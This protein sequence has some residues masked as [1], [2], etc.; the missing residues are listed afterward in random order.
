LKFGITGTFDCSYL[1]G[2]KERLLVFA[3]SQE[4][5]LRSQYELMLAHGF[6]R[7]GE[8]IYRPNCPACEA[9]QSIRIPVSSFKP[10]KSQKRV[11][12]KN[13]SLK[14]QV[15]RVHSSEYYELY[16]LYINQ[17]HADGGMYPASPEQYQQFLFSTWME[18]MFIE[19]REENELV[20][21]AVVDEMNSC[22]SALY[23][24]FD[25]EYAHRSLGTFA[26]LEQ[27]HRAGQMHKE[28][29]YLGYQI[30][31]CRKMN[32]KSNFFPHERHLGEGWMVVSR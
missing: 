12:A 8:Q 19:F 24:F 15:S 17:R 27:I 31:E 26:I 6:R 10:S 11:L 13:K 25:P 28:F 7:S 16:E 5:D 9:C 14:T 2:K 4:P 21:V 3:G 32:Y 20:M 1:P 18:P 23:T 22:L 29:V 30:D